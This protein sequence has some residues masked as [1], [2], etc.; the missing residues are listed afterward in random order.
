VHAWR[1]VNSV[2][3]ITGSPAPRYGTR[4]SPI[5]DANTRQANPVVIAAPTSDVEGADR[6]RHR[7]DRE[8]HEEDEG[9]REGT[10]HRD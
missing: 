7:G 10:D 9:V 4:T 2:T 6:Q 8:A 1:L 3:T 5:A